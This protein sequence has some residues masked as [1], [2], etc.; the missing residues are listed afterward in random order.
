VNLRAGLDDAE[1]IKFLTLPAFEVRPLGRPAR[2]SIPTELSQT[3]G[4]ILDL[5]SGGALFESL[6]GHLLS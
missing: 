4:I 5:F 1:K 3:Q 2:S 6:S